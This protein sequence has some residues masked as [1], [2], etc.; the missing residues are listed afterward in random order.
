[1][2]YGRSPR[3]ISLVD[4]SFDLHAGGQRGA[5]A[6][7]ICP[8]KPNG[9]PLCRTSIRSA[10]ACNRKSCESQRP[11]FGCPGWPVGGPR[12]SRLDAGHRIGWQVDLS[13]LWRSSRPSISREMRCERKL[14]VLAQVAP[15]RDSLDLVEGWFRL[16]NHAHQFFG[17]DISSI[18]IVMRGRRVATRR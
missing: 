13:S 10:V 5:G 7:R 4:A 6:T 18:H 15:R 12:T 17:R 9:C 3:V 1:M 11:V 14:K 8:Q 16:A 2:K